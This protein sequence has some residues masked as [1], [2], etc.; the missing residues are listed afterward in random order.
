MATIDERIV[1]LKMDNGDFQS[2]IESSIDSVSSLKSSMNLDGAS[3]SLQNLA[4]TAKTVTFD[5]A[6]ESANTLQA[7]FSTLSVAG[8]AAIEIGRA[9]V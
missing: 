5:K 1:K 2:K 4:N 7:K 8:G 9:H 3:K 6:A